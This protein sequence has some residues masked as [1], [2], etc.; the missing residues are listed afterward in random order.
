M[1]VAIAAWLDDKWRVGEREL[2]LMAF[3][4]AGKSTMVGLFAAWLLGDDPDRRVLVLSADHALARRMVRNVKRLIERHPATV[5]LKPARIDEWAADR[6][7]VERGLELRDP[8][9]L[10]KGIGANI[11]GC[12]ADIVICDDVEVPNTAGTPAKRD[13][14][15]ERL[16][17]IDYV[18][19]P[20]GLKLFVGT[21]HSRDS[22]YRADAPEG[23]DS[24][25]YL[26]G[27]D[28]LELPLLTDAGDSRWPER[29]SPQ[30]IERIR[31]RSGPAKF[32]S[33]MM[34]RAMALADG[35]L[36]VE[37]LVP[38]DADLN[39]T[40]A[41]GEAVL[42][43]GPKR[44]V[45]ASCWWD[46]AYG[47]PE[48]GDGSVIACVFTDEDGN[49]RLHGVEYLSFDR[50]RLA[51]T[52]ELTQQC[53]QAAEFAMRHYLPSITVE[54]NGFG[55]TVPGILKGVIRE[56]GEAIGVKP[57]HNTRAK[58]LRILDAFDAPLA[59]GRLYAHTSVLRTARFVAEMRDWRPDAQGP[60]D[61]LDAIAGCLLSE[62]LRL[63]R[64]AA[65]PLQPQRRDWRRGL[66]PV[67]A[68]NDFDL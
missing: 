26:A 11:T 51:E 56:R 25:P 47:D 33:Q 28:R 24:E 13:D 67:K 16:D 49:L 54:D 14:L 64:L 61:A 58:A 37:R 66:K 23:E 27:Y 30:R 5:H 40:E 19:V 52:D 7:T 32:Q 1:H 60:D 35:R 15:R 3:R 20:G 62:P 57:V 22:L 53:E 29:F 39:Y 8:S 21:P 31:M 46:P 50:A 34:L 45:S 2:L 41:G 9:M 68:R 48:R 42:R 55:K 43:L 6:F 65:P 59:A 12:R 63:P 44:L 18:L 10:A 17:E 4:G 38:Y 36:D